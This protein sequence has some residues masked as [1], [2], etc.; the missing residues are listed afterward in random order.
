MPIDI[1]LSAIIIMEAMGIVAFLTACLFFRKHR[2]ISEKH[3]MFLDALNRRLTSERGDGKCFSSDWVMDNIVYKPKKAL[4]YTPLLAAGFGLLV[5]V[6]G[7]G[8]GPQILTNFISFGYASFVALLGIAILLWTDAF[9]AYGYTNAIQNV[10]VEQLDK[11]DQSYLELAEEAL[12]KATLR[13]AFLGVAFA[14]FG[15]FIPQIFNAFVYAF[16]FYVNIYFQAS[17]ASSKVF[18]FFGAVVIMILPALLFLLPELLGR[19]IVH[20]GRL[21][22]R[23]VLDRGKS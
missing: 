18:S 4:N 1:D 9:E 8:V 7:M 11:E 22:A 23:R 15:P 20:R 3:R 16:A 10:S 21:L 5:A 12:E 2:R 6:L 14:M 13:F 17:E 19:I